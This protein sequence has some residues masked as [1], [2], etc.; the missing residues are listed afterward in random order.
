MR[1]K[2]ILLFG[3]VSVMCACEKKLDQVPISQASAA[4]F[5]RNTADFEVAVNG[6]YQSLLVGEYGINQFD[7]AEVRS[8]NIYSP[9]TSGVRDWLPR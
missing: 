4:N 5:F 9:G 3:L 2:F 1:K 7:M 6:I 8:D